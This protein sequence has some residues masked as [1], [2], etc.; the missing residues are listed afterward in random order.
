M[1]TR[2]RAWFHAP[3]EAWAW[4]VSL[5]LVIASVLVATIRAG[6]DGWIP[7]NDA[8]PMV[9]RSSHSL[10]AH[11]TWFGLYA[12]PTSEALGEP[13]FTLGPWQLWWMWLPIRLMGTTWGP[14]LSMAALNSAWIMLTTW[15]V[16]RHMG[17]RYAIAVTVFFAALIW[18][19]SADTFFSPV[20]VV[21]TIPPLAA[22]CFIAWLVALGDR[23]SIL[24]FALAANI[25]VLG[26]PEA[27]LIVAMVG[28]AALVAF[29]LHV[30]RER[31][32]APQSWPEARRATLG[33]L[34]AAVGVAVVA[35]LPPLGQELFGDPGNITNMIRGHAA[36]DTSWLSPG[37]CIQAASSLFA[38][39]PFWFRDSTEHSFLTLTGALPSP[40][41]A[42]VSLTVLGLVI[43]ALVVLA[44]RRR[45]RTSVVTLALGAVAVASS[46]VH[47]LNAPY[48]QYFLPL[49]VVA[50]FTTFAV[51]IAM[52]RSAPRPVI[53]RGV[54][55][56]VGLG[57][58]LF[59]VTF[60]RT[61]IPHSTAGSM[62]EIRDSHYLNDRVLPELRGQGTVMLQP[63]FTGMF[64]YAS[65]LAIALD[66]ANIP[67]CARRIV[68]F[69]GF[70]DP[71]CS[72]PGRRISVTYQS[73]ARFI[74]LHPGERLLA[75]IDRLTPA[76]Q[77]TFGELSLAIW[78]GLGSLGAAGRPL[79]RT[80]AYRALVEDARHP[81]LAQLDA[82]SAELFDDPRRI[83]ADFDTRDD[84]ARLITMTDDASGGRVSVAGLPGVSGT[85]LVLWARLLQRL[86]RG[87]IVI[88]A[89]DDRRVGAR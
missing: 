80:A 26:H 43:V 61:D 56:A 34:A 32:T 12:W 16:K 17:Y 63:A 30:V 64:P 2:T 38:G 53:V 24:W 28:F 68:S 87:I 20:P 75:R 88:A 79:E 13:T 40:R 50:M 7:T 74:A 89:P 36:S 15:L 65:A 8:A 72:T 57:V 67:V 55:V 78:N 5:G 42:V 11:P 85:D 73:G 1:T 6:L 58:A 46:I 29:A 3:P 25:L 33:S 66:N 51:T 59:L 18:T 4:R 14:L 82:D 86:D 70:H 52:I 48:G 71:D 39:P 27:S 31:R 47:A 84:F 44:I 22:F 37:R 69:I 35:W 54:P 83:T 41:A 62:A 10:G 77:R 23:R 76:E 49:W 19:I 21:A 81:S 45:D 60:P 9:M